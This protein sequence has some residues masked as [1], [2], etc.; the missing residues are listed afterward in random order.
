[1]NTI[2]QSIKSA[3]NDAKQLDEQ[4]TKPKP[5]EQ[6][7]KPKPNEQIGKCLPNHQL[8]ICNGSWFNDQAISLT[9][10]NKDVQKD[11][12]ELVVASSTHGDFARVHLNEQN[13]VTDFFIYSFLFD[14]CF[15]RSE[16]ALKR[17]KK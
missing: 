13:L 11:W 8:L 15:T 4:Q 16:L 7:T 1:M 2:T 9:F 10:A 5:T 17:S 6:Q 3:L 12:D 14:H